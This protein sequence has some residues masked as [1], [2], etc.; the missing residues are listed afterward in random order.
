MTRPFFSRERI[1][2][3]E[4][5]GRHA[6]TAL[7]AARMRAREG[8][9]VDVQDLVSRFTIDSATEFLFGH[10]VHALRSPLPYPTT[11]TLS[12]K[13]LASSQGRL[14]KSQG[15]DA[16]SRFAEA[17]ANAQLAA[18]KRGH[19][20]SVWPL[21]EFWKANTADGM[22]VIDAYI[23]PILH[24]AVVKKR[25]S[26]MNETAGKER[27]IEDGDTLLDHLIHQTE[28]RCRLCGPS[29]WADRCFRH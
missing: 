5:F 6:D 1:S 3:F 13:G 12:E 23:D 20:N 11:H 28:G 14:E 2:H 10:C 17:F 8:V 16:A 9:A 19:Y 21:F 7:D 26:G 15:Q 29:P 18:A 27:E 25:A 22:A 24:E 4:L